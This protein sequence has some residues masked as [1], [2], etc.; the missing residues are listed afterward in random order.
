MIL[1]IKKLHALNQH[2]HK[3]WI[4]LDE[5]SSFKKGVL[6]A[7][8]SHNTKTFAI[9]TIE[10]ISLEF[11]WRVT[12]NIKIKVLKN[13]IYLCT[14]ISLKVTIQITDSCLN[15]NIPWSDLDF[16]IEKNR[17]PN[18]LLWPRKENKRLCS[19]RSTPNCSPHFVPA[20]NAA[21]AACVPGIRWGCNKDVYQVL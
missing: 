12:K 19:A 4:G 17:T 21:V 2:C 20:H 9:N 6:I 1:H 15:W 10:K 18:G 7:T 11:T 13:T 3:G 16:H 8:F 14:I 5:L